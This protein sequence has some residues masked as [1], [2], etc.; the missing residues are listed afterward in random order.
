ALE[1][2]EQIE[3]GLR[4]QFIQHLLGREI[5][6]SD[7][8]ALA[9]RAE[10][11]RQPVKRR[12]GERFELFERRCLDRAPGER[13]G[14]YRIGHGRSF[15]RAPTGGQGIAI[16]PRISAGG[17]WTLTAARRWASVGQSQRAKAKMRRATAVMIVA[18]AAALGSADASVAQFLPH[19][20]RSPQGSPPSRPPPARARTRIRG[21]PPPPYPTPSPTH[22]RPY[23]SPSPAPAP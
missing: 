9:Q 4:A 7:D 19:A 13:I 21:T 2:A 11:L 3:F 23:P 10:F 8:E 17:A 22:P 6:H 16:V 15:K 12:L 1:Q 18:G 5:L 14:K 20:T